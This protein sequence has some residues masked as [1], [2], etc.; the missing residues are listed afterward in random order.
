MG[1]CEV[2][3]F[4]SS[5]G[6]EDVSI[7]ELREKHRLDLENLTL[8]TQPLKTLH[9]FT[10]ATSLYL[11]RSLV[12]ILSKGCPLML[13]CILLVACGFVLM[14]IDGPH[15]QLKYAI[16]IDFLKLPV[17][18]F[19]HVEE[20][21]RY[22][23]FGLWWVALGVASSIG[24]GS[25]LHTFVLYL[26]PHIA[27]FTIKATQC[28]RVDLKSAPYDTIQMKSAPS[29]LGKDCSRFGPPVFQS[30]PGSLVRVPLM[31][32]LWNVQLEAVLWGFG[33][34]LGE[35]PPYFISRAERLK[36]ATK[37]LVFKIHLKCV[38]SGI[39]LAKLVMRVGYRMGGT[40]GRFEVVEYYMLLGHL[41]GVLSYLLVVAG[42]RGL[43]GTEDNKVPNPLFDLA[44]IMCGQF[45][46][47]FWKF[48][49]ATLIGKA[50]IKTHL[51]TT[52]VIALCNNLILQWLENELFWVL[53]LVPGVSSVMP[54]VIAKVHMIREN[55]LLSSDP[56][57]SYTEG[58]P[59]NLSFALIWNSVVWI[60]LLNFFVKIVM[61]TAQSLLKK[62]QESEMTN[63]LASLNYT[64]SSLTN[65]KPNSA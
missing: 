40:Y 47:P 50:I 56:S 36:G 18:L 29:W 59:W 4:P 16:R 34:A 53:G 12:Y 23:T 17:T 51:Q 15:M 1:S 22:F 46:I 61:T 30:M 65:G 8:T 21:T 39:H 37:S 41:A 44:G 49:L 25:G 9:L 64:S 20:I 31:S 57:P 27:L 2:G 48:F 43:S 24:L 54:T 13:L 35:L 14:S 58:K 3:E 63:K 42:D 62:Q 19:H 60:M 33:T 52:F 28:G 10:L 45:G 55:Y 7:R 11:K 38:Q 5:D 26:G 6:V 32:I